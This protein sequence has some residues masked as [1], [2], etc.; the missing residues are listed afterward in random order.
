MSNFSHTESEKIMNTNAS[1]SFLEKLEIQSRIGCKCKQIK[2]T[3]WKLKNCRCILKKFIRV[4]GL[5][6][7]NGNEKLKQN[8]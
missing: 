2:N 8:H 3:T 5:I 4:R 1:Y 7:L 6:V